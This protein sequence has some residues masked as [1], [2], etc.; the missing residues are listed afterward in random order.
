MFYKYYRVRQRNVPG[1]TTPLVNLND[2]DFKPTN[3]KMWPFLEES[4]LNEYVNECHE[5]E[6]A[7]ITT[8]RVCTIIDAYYEKANFYT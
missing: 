2:Y 6:T 7:R 5:L 8:K 4:F 3:R 1:I